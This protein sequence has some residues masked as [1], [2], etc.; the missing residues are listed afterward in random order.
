MS[1]LDVLIAPDLPP[2]DAMGWLLRDGAVR[3]LLARVLHTLSGEPVL[4]GARPKIDLPDY[5]TAPHALVL[6][7]ADLTGARLD[8]R[9]GPAHAILLDRLD[10]VRGAA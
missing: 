9:R 3:D 8:G 7:L 10:L 6:D 5:V 1:P 4:T 2:S